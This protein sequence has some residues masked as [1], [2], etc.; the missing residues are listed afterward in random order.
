MQP[1]DKP[2]QPRIKFP[3]RTFGKKA[4]A[5]NAQWYSTYTWLEYS[6]KNAFP[7]E[8]LKGVLTLIHHSQLSLDLKI[9]SM[10]LVKQDDCINMSEVLFMCNQLFLG[11]S[12]S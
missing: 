12:I 2:K 5:F 6:V 11:S 1:F 3:M 4:R 9:G 10:P 7:V 8:C